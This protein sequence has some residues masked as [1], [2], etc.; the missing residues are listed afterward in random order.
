MAIVREQT[1]SSMSI[2][3]R[4]GQDASG[5]YRFK[6][7]TIS[8]LKDDIDLS[9]EG[10]NIVAVGNLAEN[11][12]LGTVDGFRVVLTSVLYDND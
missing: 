9:T 12:I 3:V 5:N 4:N 8:G 11:L 2:R 1:K 10:S 6:Y 7:V